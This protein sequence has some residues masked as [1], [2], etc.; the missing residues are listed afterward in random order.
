[1]GKRKRRP[2]AS[3]GKTCFFKLIARG[4]INAVLTSP[5][6]KLTYSAF[7][8]IMRKNEGDGVRQSNHSQLRIDDPYFDR[9]EVG[10][11]IFTLE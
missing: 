7:G 5:Q 11:F 9:F 8:Q 4:A 3:S 10:V 1:V 6:P 2:S